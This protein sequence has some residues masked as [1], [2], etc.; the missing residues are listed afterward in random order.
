MLELATPKRMSIVSHKAIPDILVENLF[1]LEFEFEVDLTGVS[2]RRTHVLAARNNI[3]TTRRTTSKTIRDSADIISARDM[4]EV[5]V[6][7]M[8]W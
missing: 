3:D 8:R 6:V 1:V 7:E 4:V 2:E 5:V